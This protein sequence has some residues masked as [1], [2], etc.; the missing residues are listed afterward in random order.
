[1][2]QNRPK[3]EKFVKQCIPS[4]TAATFSPTS[5]WGGWVAVGVWGESRKPAKIGAV[6]ESAWRFGPEDLVKTKFIIIY[7]KK[8]MD[9]AFQI[10]K[11]I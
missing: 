6:R 10:F 4:L 3:P 7:C 1:M 2:P 5:R 9:R 11:K 8:S